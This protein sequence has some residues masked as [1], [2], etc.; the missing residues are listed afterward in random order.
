MES[1][2]LGDSVI[3]IVSSSHRHDKRNNPYAT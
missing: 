1:I 2:I 3:L